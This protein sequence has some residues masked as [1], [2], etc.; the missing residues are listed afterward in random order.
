MVTSPSFR[1]LLEECVLPLLQKQALLAFPEDARHRDEYILIF[2]IE[3]LMTIQSNEHHLRSPFARHRRIDRNKALDKLKNNSKPDHFVIA[4]LEKI[5][6]V[7]QKVSR[8]EVLQ[9]VEDILPKA[10]KT[11][12]GQGREL[13]FPQWEWVLC[14]VA[15]KAVTNAIGRNSS[16]RD[17]KMKVCIY[18]IYIYIYMCVCVYIQYICCIYT[19]ICA[20]VDGN[21]SSLC[22]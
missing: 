1:R 11:S 15:V 16:V 5:K 21:S 13:T 2:S 14:I 7:P 17:A 22:W 9:F 6:I 8:T 19:C 12:Q 3:I 4:A 18:N 10:D 20:R